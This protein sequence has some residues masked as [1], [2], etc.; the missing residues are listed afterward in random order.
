MKNATNSTIIDNSHSSQGSD[1]ILNKINPSND[2]VIPC[3][4]TRSL[5]NS[6]AKMHTYAALGTSRDMRQNG[7]NNIIISTN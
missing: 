2:D 7:Y 6:I 4:D 3:H 1:F 5:L